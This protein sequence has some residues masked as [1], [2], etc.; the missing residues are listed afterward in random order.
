M[1][2]AKRAAM[3][4]VGPGTGRLH[5]ASARMTRVMEIARNRVKKCVGIA[6]SR[7]K[8]RPPNCVEKVGARA[9][10]RVIRF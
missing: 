3:P 6:L 7:V 9:S 8:A 4:P 5:G 1:E 2:P 10:I